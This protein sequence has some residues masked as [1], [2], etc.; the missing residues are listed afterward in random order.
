MS[1][2]RANPSSADII[3]GVYYPSSDGMPMAET[4]THVL[5][6]LRAIALLSHY[7][8][9]RS[10]VLVAGN[11]FWY[12]EKGNPKKRRSPDVMVVKGVPA[13]QVKRSFRSWDHGVNPCFILEMTSKETV[14]EDLVEKRELYERFGVREYFLFDP[15]N[16]YLDSQLMGY[17]LVNGHYEPVAAESDGQLLSEELGLWLFPDGE[18]LRYVDATTNEEL[19]DLPDMAERIEE[20]REERARLQQSVCRAEQRAEANAQQLAVERQRAE[21]AERRAAELAAELARLRSQ[22][23]PPATEGPQQP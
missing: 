5:Q 23:Q 20:L 16:E 12:Y 8:R 17:R 4:L 22:N 14:K 10:D 6:I 13:N 3:D 19:L 9:H 21:E 15:L 2:I 1:S 11:I 7:F 18:N